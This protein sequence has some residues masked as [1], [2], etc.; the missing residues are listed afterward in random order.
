[1]DSAQLKVVSTPQLFDEVDKR[2][3]LDAV[4][5]LGI[6][7]GDPRGAIDFRGKGHG[8]GVAERRKRQHERRDGESHGHKLR[9][10]EINV[11]CSHRVLS[12]LPK[13]DETLFHNGV[14]FERSCGWTCISSCDQ[15]GQYRTKR[16]EQDY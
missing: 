4:D 14:V 7:L 2:D 15:G 8:L 16:Y 5:F 13:V 10:L 3:V 12:T 11:G 6:D 1:L 9:K